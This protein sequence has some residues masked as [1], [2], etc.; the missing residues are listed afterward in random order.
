[1]PHYNAGVSPALIM[2]T[3]VSGMIRSTMK[4]SYVLI[5][6]SLLAVA[7]ALRAEQ[8][9]IPDYE[10]A[11]SLFWRVLYNQGGETL[12]CGNQFSTDR[13]GLNVEHVFP[14][15]WVTRELRCGKRNQCRRRSKRFNR[16]EADL[17]N[18]YPARR[19]IN[20]ARRSYR[21]AE[22]PGEQRQ[23]G[24]C[25]FEI[26]D[27]QRTIEPRP[28]SRGEIARAMFYMRDTYDLPIFRKQTELLLH[29][30]RT[31]PPSDE[32]HRRND[33]IDK[34]QGTRNLYIDKPELAR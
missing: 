13:R 15:S 16:I 5:V 31:D 10:T 20:D 18:L 25:D 34:I 22:I 3:C 26:D 7:S 33:L 12:Y 11:R 27:R 24:S 30:H 29:W 9:R 1:M 6:F 23:F 28:A 21:F 4:F 2:D 14:M 17:H 19:E 8:Q 32:E